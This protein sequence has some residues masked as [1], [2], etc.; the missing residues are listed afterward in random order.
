MPD[1]NP[2]TILLYRGINAEILPS[3]K[4]LLFIEDLIYHIFSHPYPHLMSPVALR[5]SVEEAVR[6]FEKLKDAEE[7]RELMDEHYAG[8]RQYSVFVSATESE[9]EATF[10]AGSGDD[11]GQWGLVVRFRH[12]GRYVRYSPRFA[13]GNYDEI[14]VV[15]GAD[16]ASIEK[17]TMIGRSSNEPFT[18]HY[19]YKRM[20]DDKIEKFRSPNPERFHKLRNIRWSPETFFTERK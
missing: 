18:T 11:T 6:R 12:A 2:E 5:Y 1:E 8:D 4:N 19:I 9:E 14:L 13:I 3:K 7:S 15:G 10:F 20:E 16:P 17:I